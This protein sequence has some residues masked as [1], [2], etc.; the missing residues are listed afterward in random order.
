LTRRRSTRFGSCST[1]TTIATDDFRTLAHEAAAT[2]DTLAVASEDA[3]TLVDLGLRR[4]SS[5]C[6]YMVA[7]NPF[8]SEADRFFEFIGHALRGDRP[9]AISYT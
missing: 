5:T 4:P 1:C 3:T 6:T 7:D 8:G 9:P 2:R